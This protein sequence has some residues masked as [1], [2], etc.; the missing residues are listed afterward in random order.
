MLIIA[1]V[2]AATNALN[3]SRE[4]RVSSYS[5]ITV[6]L[7]GNAPHSFCLRFF[8]T[9]ARKRCWKEVL[10]RGAGKRCW[11]EVL[12]RGAGNRCWEE[13]MGRGAGMRCWEEVL[14]RGARKRCWEEVLGR[15]AGK[16]CRK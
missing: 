16:M 12:G 8:N 14:G 6:I 4:K 5:R 11:E 10:G 1:D 13:V 15:G 2:E 7:F 9:S 3:A